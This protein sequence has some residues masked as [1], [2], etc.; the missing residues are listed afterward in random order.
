MNKT[1]CSFTNNTS[2]DTFQLK[3]QFTSK[4]PVYLVSSTEEQKDY[5]LK[6]FPKTSTGKAQYEKEGLVTSL[7]HQNVIKSFPVEYEG[8]SDSYAFLTEYAKYGDL[9]EL[10]NNG[11]IINNDSI[12]RTLFHQLV[13][14]ISYIHSKG[15]A[16][17]DLKLENITLGSDF[18]VKIIDFDQSQIISDKS[19]SSAGTRCYRAPE[20]LNQTCTDLEAVD[21]YSFGVILY[22]LKLREFPFIEKMTKNGNLGVSNSLFHKNNNLFWNLKTESC[23][24]TKP[25]SRDFIDLINGMLEIDP[26]KRWKLDDIKCSG[27]YKGTVL[28]ERSLKIRMRACLANVHLQNSEVN[29]RSF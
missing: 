21:V 8:H 19:I 24:K 7:R 23:D 9:L 5:V 17:L 29:T 12:I 15:S 20:I 26:S 14:G 10:L 27:W 13:E 18:Q 28:S 3:K 22:I 25:P 6:L 1:L 16:H 4:F 2:K 11:F